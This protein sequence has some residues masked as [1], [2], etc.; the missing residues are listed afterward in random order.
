MLSV[1]DPEFLTLGD[2]NLA[3]SILTFLIIKR[4]AVRG[5]DCRWQDGISFTFGV[6]GS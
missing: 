1:D 5:D 4:T 3:E 6:L 2:G